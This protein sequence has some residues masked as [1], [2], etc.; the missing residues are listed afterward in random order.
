[1][2]KNF[3]KWKL[4]YKAY[5]KILKNVKASATIDIE[6]EDG[7]KVTLPRRP[8]GHKATP[9][10]MKK[11]VAA[12]A[13]SETLKGWIP[14]KEEA[15]SMREESKC[16]EKEATCNHSLTSQK[17]Q[18]KVEKSMEKAKAIEAEAKL[19]AEEREIMLVDT[20]NM[21]EGQKA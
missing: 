14:N 4:P 16:R 15:I 18:L 8:R 17:R 9:A 10:D 6:D 1:V 21:T 11:D 5:E 12:L 3:K 20:T 2:L 19:M 7:D 13:L